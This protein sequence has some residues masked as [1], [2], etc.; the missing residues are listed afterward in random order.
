MDEQGAIGGVEGLEIY[1]FKG[2]ENAY[3][4]EARFGFYDVSMVKDGL[5]YIC[6][7]LILG[8]FVARGEHY[9]GCLG[10]TCIQAPIT[11]GLCM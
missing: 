9:I 5:G 6:M 8:D 2:V 7:H 4:Y 11:C 10:I 3:A 1:S